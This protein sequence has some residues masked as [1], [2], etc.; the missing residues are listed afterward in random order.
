MVVFQ[1]LSWES[2]DDEDENQHIISIFGKTKNGESVC[3]STHFDSYFFIKV[4]KD[5]KKNDAKELKE[6]YLK[7]CC[8]YN[9]VSKKD[10]WG[11]KNNEKD[12]FMKVSFKTLSNMKKTSYGLQKKLDEL[13]TPVDVFG[14]IKK[15]YNC[16]TNFIIYESNI[17]PVLRLMHRTGIKSTGWMDSGECSKN[18]I[19]NVDIDLFC[20]NWELLQ[21]VDRD[22]VAPFIVASF[23][24]E[25]NSSTGK[26]PNPEI[27]GDC[28]FQIGVTLKRLNEPEPFKRICF[29]YKNTKSYDCVSFVTESEMMVA[30]SKYIQKNNVD[31]LTGYNIWGFDLKFLAIRAEKLG[32]NLE[33][34]R[35]GRFKNE[36][37]E[38]SSKKLSSSALG[39]NMLH[40]IP[41][42]GRYTFDLF[43][44]IKKQYKFDSYKLDYVSEKFLGDHKIDM[45]PE[46]M[47]KRFKEGDPVK[48]GEVAEYCIKDTLLPH[49]LVDKLCIITNMLEMAKATWVPINFLAER[50]QQIKVMS[51]L[52]NTSRKMNFCI[53]TLKYGHVTE[54]SYEGATVLEAQTGAYYKPITALDFESLYPSIMIAHNLCYSSLVMNS[55]YD[56]LPGVEYETFNIG[57]KVYKFVQNIE[58][59]VPTLLKDLRVCRK[60]AK[61]KKAAASG[62]MVFI[63]DGQQLAYKISSNSV[64]G[65]TGAGKG[66]LP[67]VPI[68][69][70]VTGTGRKMIE[71][72]K[73][74]VEE[75]FPG[76]KVR[77]GD[78]DSVMVEFDVGSLTGVDAVKYSWEIGEQAAEQCTKLFKKPNNLELEKV[79]WP[80][81]LY[82][83]KRYGAKLWEK[84]KGE[85]KMKYVDVKGLQMVRRDNTLYVRET[86]KELLDVIL[87]SDNPEPALELAKLKANELICG[88]VPTN[89]LLLS[90]QLGDSYKSQNLAHVQVRNKMKERKEGSEPQSGDRVPYVFVKT[91]NPKAKGFEKAEDPKWVEENNIP[92]DYYYYFTNKFMNPVID[93]IEPITKSRDIFDYLIEKKKP[94]KD[95]KQRSLL[96]MWNTVK[97]ES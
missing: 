60:E 24:I 35:L 3:V 85:M 25:C 7:L 42:A 80:Y 54:D 51:Q 6:K 31:I 87:E 58:S 70:T 48:L 96:D 89:K 11:F 77:Y 37:S 97:S 27:D 12:I 69:S 72:T 95:T 17:D 47:F 33:F 78:T 91:D 84:D 15:F 92:I 61:K 34:F 10:I 9:F 52:A 65:F 36:L 43:Q 94:K 40:M 14:K 50:G 20:N 46:E 66:M 90:Q 86:L 59:P 22:D 75:N 1:V 29:C 55:K 83:K 49:R 16:G 88:L 53:P 62:F 30:F 93:L 79:Y 39:D 45:S 21:P 82:S 13:V 28:C 57:D 76:A 18:S 81:I 44:E 26:F 74:Y 23:D 73:N 68:A 67:C 19:A 8:D 64:Y 5:F 56:N 32:C 41:M 71:T 4:P 2:R 63:Y 38:L